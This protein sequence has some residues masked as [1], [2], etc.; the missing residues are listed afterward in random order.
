MKL[1]IEQLENLFSKYPSTDLDIKYFESINLGDQKFLPTDIV[2]KDHI[3]RLAKNKIQEIEVIYTPQLYDFVH[4]L[5]PAEFRGPYGS[6]EFMEMDR[7][8]E[9]LDTINTHS[10]RKRYIRMIGDVYGIDTKEGKRTIILR[11]DEKL[12]YRK[13]NDLKR[14]FSKKQKFLYRTSECGIIIFVNLS[15]NSDS[16]YVMRFK[17]NT[18]L[19]SILVSK[20]DCKE[21][22]APDF[23]STEDVISVT[24]P[25]DLLNQYIASEARLIIIGDIL[26]DLYKKALLDLRKYDKYVRMI[27]VPELDYTNIEHFIKQVKLVYNSDR[28]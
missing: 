18:D 20:K 27:V 15:M 5:Y 22:I 6:M 14:L 25:D 28:W 12:N 13:W 21:D 16:A 1:T 23:I 24:D 4:G 10:Y 2:L 19:I 26:D 7:Y 9:L 11:H 3:P 17:K 8:L